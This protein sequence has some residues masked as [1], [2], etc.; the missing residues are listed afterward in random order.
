[1]KIRKKIILNFWVPY[2]LQSYPLLPIKI[3]TS[4]SALANEHVEYFYNSKLNPL[5][6]RSSYFL[7]SKR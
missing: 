2:F 1:M 5:F 7:G 6:N 3:G 4:R